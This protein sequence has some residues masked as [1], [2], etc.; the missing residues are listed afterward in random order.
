MKKISRLFNTK[1]VF[2]FAS[3][4]TLVAC[5]NDDNNEP[6]IDEEPEPVG[7]VVEGCDSF[8]EALPSLNTA[9][10]D[11]ECNGNPF[12]EEGALS[13]ANL[14]GTWGRFGGAA[15]VEYL[16]LDYVDNPNPGTVN[17]SSKV[18]KIE[19]DAGIEPWA[20]FFFNLNE[21]IVF[22]AGQEA[23]SI[24][25]HSAA[26]GQNVLLKIEDSSNSDN[27]KEA[28]V[29]T[30]ATGTWEKLVY[31]F[32]AEDS[33]KYDRIVII[34]AINIT[35]SAETTYYIDNIAFSTPVAVEEVSSPTAA[36]TAPSLDAADVMSVFSDSYT[37]VAGTDFNPN[38]GQSTQV[39]T[40]DLGGNSVLKYA[41]LNYQGTAFASALDVSGYTSIHLDYWTS[42][43]TAL[44]FFLIS[45]GEG[46]E[47]AK[48]LD[49]SSLGEWKSVD[50]ALT[51]FSDVVDLADVIQF[52]VDGN[53]T[54]FFDNIYFHGETPVASSPETGPEAPTAAAEDV[55]SIF[56]D[57]YTDVE[58][59]NFNPDW[60]Q[61][62]QVTTEVLADNSV[63]K[64]TNLNYQGTE[65]TAQDVSAYSSIH[66]DY[67]SADQT[68]VDFFLISNEPTTEVK[69]TI[70]ITPGEW[71]SID[72]PLSEFSPV[73][74]N[75]VFQFKIVGAGTV[76]FDNIYFHGETPVASSPETG[77]EAP[78]AVAEDVLSIFSDSYTDVEGTNFNPDWGQSTQVTT[79]VLADNSVLKYTNLNYQGTEFT[80]QDVSAYSSIHIDYWSADQTTVDFF[81]ISNEPTTEVKK[82]I[83]I[84]PGEWNSIDIPL[85]EFS[86]VELNK[87]FQFKIVGAGTIFFDNF[88][89]KK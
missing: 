3:A 86:P 83:A 40:E 15:G 53:G 39:S 4:L 62:T 80:A 38:W 85:S 27:F 69:K 14:T 60:G 56:S 68:T 84:T 71:N 75:K 57:S 67:W 19:E 73:E 29:T 87:V 61:S 31:N 44:N 76:F 26:P 34:T 74:L 33:N 41:S 18:L 59:T 58:G 46:K 45:S 82:T 30:T 13:D 66:I 54:V 6:I 35:N 16:E 88:Y 1:Q 72:I 11:F 63:L 12:S 55:L 36:P 70:A 78:T 10:I 25:V 22:P 50:I 32:S 64:Y 52:K 65:F 23:I 8:T 89:F 28:T 81:L 42:D 20:G 5:S 79:E 51:D 17:S 24:D 77:P 21:K 47:K 37:D 43:S 9:T 48:A 2:L 49:V 7:V